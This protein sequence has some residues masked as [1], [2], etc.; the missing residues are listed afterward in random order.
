MAEVLTVLP[1]QNTVATMRLRGTDLI[2]ALENG[3]SQVEET[4]GRF[5]QVAGIRFSWTRSRPAL[6]GRVLEVLVEEDGDWKPIDPDAEYVVATN[7]YLLAGGDGYK[8]FQS[9]AMD[10]RAF[11]PG[12]D[13]VVVDYLGRHP[14]YVPYVDGRIIEK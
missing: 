8:V 9:G 12:L 14:E 10:A 5:P 3:V 13:E 2:A 4:K 11:G 1:F 6:S 7:D